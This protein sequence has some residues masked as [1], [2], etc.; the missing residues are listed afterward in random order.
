MGIPQFQ[1][2]MSVLYPRDEQEIKDEHASS[3]DDEAY[4]RLVR[5]QNERVRLAA[6]LL[7]VLP[8]TNS[9]RR[10]SRLYN[11]ARSW[12][13][14]TS[15]PRDEDSGPQ[16]PANP[17]DVRIYDTFLHVQE[18]QYN[19]QEVSKCVHDAGLRI[20]EWMDQDIGNYQLHF[21]DDVDT[22]DANVIRDLVRSLRSEEDRLAFGEAFNG[23]A[24]G[25]RVTVVREDNPSRSGWQRWIDR[26]G[27]TTA[28][29]S[30]TVLC[31]AF[32]EFS[33]VSPNAP[34]ITNTLT[35]LREQV[36]ELNVAIPGVSLE[37]VLRR[38]DCRRDLRAV[39]LDLAKDGRHVE[40]DVLVAFVSALYGELRHPESH[41][42]FMHGRS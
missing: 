9:L 39:H 21:D 11:I 27:A 35:L 33:R 25:H 19:I 10:N 28:I 40:I 2:M 18:E 16:G 37:D 41:L 30:R 26:R 14:S 1:R 36:G 6:A 5:K 12:A 8:S 31:P 32:K 13:S 34:V 23:L 22:R 15:P 42:L 3:K 7:R 17:S 4:V 20:Q 38:F 29:D 24:A